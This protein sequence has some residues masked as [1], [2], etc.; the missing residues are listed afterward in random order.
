MKNLKSLIK[1]LVKVDAENECVEFKEN[2]SEP[3]MIGE[4]VSALSNSATYHDRQY[5]YL[6]WGVNDE[7]HEYPDTT[8]NFRTKKGAG[9]EDLEP[10][11]RRLLD[12]NVISRNSW[13]RRK[14]VAT[15]TCL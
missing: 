14:K 11:L 13:Q 15:M 10:W 3:E 5:A 7:T 4:Y 9:N 12:L 8:F 6:V 1:E 2:N